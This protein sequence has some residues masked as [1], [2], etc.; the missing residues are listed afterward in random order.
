MLKGCD[1]GARH[2]SRR[3][4]RETRAADAP[5]PRKPRASPTTPSAPRSLPSPV[6]HALSTTVLPT[7]SLTSACTSSALSSSA[8][9]SFLPGIASL[10]GSLAS[11]LALCW[12]RL[13]GGASAASM[14]EG[15]ESLPWHAK[16]TH[17]APS[18]ARFTLSFSASG[19]VNRHTPSELSNACPP[20]VSVSEL[21]ASTLATAIASFKAEGRPASI[22]QPAARA[23]SPTTTAHGCVLRL[24]RR[25]GRSWHEQTAPRLSC[26]SSATVRASLW[27]RARETRRE[28]EQR[29][30]Q[31][32]AATHAV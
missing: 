18:I 23:G 14:R 17:A 21:L 7:P 31:R 24:P 11:P 26:S 9:H 32:L 27:W 29:R 2:S 28:G 19:P 4:H 8:L 15:A 13:V 16:C 6:L 22:S 12:S 3:Y 25:A 10:P 1:S 5:A 30:V 20:S